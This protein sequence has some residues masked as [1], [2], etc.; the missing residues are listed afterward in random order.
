[1]HEFGALQG[2]PHPGGPDYDRLSIGCEF[3]R[4]LSLCCGN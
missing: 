1:M 3:C 2:M 4:N